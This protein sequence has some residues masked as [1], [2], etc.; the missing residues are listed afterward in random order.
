MG[1]CGCGCVRERER[2]SRLATSLKNI[3]KFSLLLLTEITSKRTRDSSISM[4][5][6][7]YEGLDGG[8]GSGIHYSLKN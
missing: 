4:K 2:E 1:G 8:G 5:P 6:D 3:E 7:Y